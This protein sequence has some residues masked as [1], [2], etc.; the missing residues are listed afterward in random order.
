MQPPY[1]AADF[2][3]AP[4]EQMPRTACPNFLASIR[5]SRRKVLRTGAWGFWGCR[6]RGCCAGGRRPV[7]RRRRGEQFGRAK[8]CILL[9]MW[10]GPAQQETWD[11]KPD[12]PA[13]IRGEFSPIATRM[14]GIQISE[15]FPQLSLRTDRL[16]IVRSMTHTNVDHTTAT[17]FSA[18]RSAAAGR[19]QSAQRLAAHRRGAGAVGIWAG[20]V[21]AVR[22][23]AAEARE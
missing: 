21:A 12:A 10:G 4:A 14:P 5:P 18:D 13:E 16:A 20:T 8:S 3:R 19:W 9:F 22:F 1:A 2:S 7:S 23:D 6:C 11:L 17:S 15:H